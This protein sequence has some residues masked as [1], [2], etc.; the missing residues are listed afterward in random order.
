LPL[1][2]FTGLSFLDTLALI[3]GAW[4][5]CMAGGIRMN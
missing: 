5:I 2:H 4:E 3:L 1:A